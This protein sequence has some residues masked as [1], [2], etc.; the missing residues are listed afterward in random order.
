MS[1]DITTLLAILAMAGATAVTRIAGIL[2][3]RHVR[4]SVRMQDILGAIPPA[5]L[6]A[7]VAPTALATGWAETIACALTALTALRLPLLAATFLGVA[8]VALLRMAG[9]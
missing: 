2:L 3:V 6:M 9:L 1:L 5:V 7:V 4:M 8:C